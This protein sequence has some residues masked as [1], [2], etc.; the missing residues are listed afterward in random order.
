MN[1]AAILGVVCVITATAIFIAGGNVII[2]SSGSMAPAIPA[3]AVAL[4]VPTPADTIAKGDVI[5]VRRDD[6]RLVTH[7]V[8]EA[9]TSQHMTRVTLRGD[10][11]ASDDPHP[12]ALQGS[13]QRVLWS[14]PELGRVMAAAQSPWLLLPV[15]ALLILLL[16]PTRRAHTSRPTGGDPGH[17]DSVPV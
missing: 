5:T 6:G 1:A 12:Y 3:G 9:T 4:T 7:R 13:V 10:A 8:Q 17:G 15:A 11:N 14:V 16:L 2:F